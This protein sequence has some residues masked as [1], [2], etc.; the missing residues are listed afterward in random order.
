[1]DFEVLN[2]NPNIGG[3][4]HAPQLQNLILEMANHV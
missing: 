4:F 1:M 3:I 2:R